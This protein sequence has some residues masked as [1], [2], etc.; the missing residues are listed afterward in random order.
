[1]IVLEELIRYK[2][3]TYANQGENDVEGFQIFT[4]EFIVNDMINA[5]G[6][7]EVLDF[8]KTILEPTSGDGAF[9]G[10]IL[11]K[12]LKSIKDNYAVNSLRALSTI[13]S[14]EMDKS[15]ILKQRNNIYT[16]MMNYA[17]KHNIY[18]KPFDIVLKD[19]IYSNFIWGQTNVDDELDSLF[20]VAVAYLM[21]DKGPDI[22]TPVNFYSWK[23]NEDLTYEKI[24]EVIDL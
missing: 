9:T 21:T 12:R 17:E 16:I 14:I 23:I 1:M 2:V 10:R 8:S 5:I 4:P 18:S 20:G 13:Y 24:L 19:I 15:L 7:K 3:P 6:K 22:F 11:E